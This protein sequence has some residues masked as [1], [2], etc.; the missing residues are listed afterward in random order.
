MW[1]RIKAALRR[2]GVIERGVSLVVR[3]ELI[4]LIEQQGNEMEKALRPFQKTP[5]A[6]EIQE[7]WVA[8]SEETVKA[9]E[10]LTQEMVDEVTRKLFE[11]NFEELMKLEVDIAVT[12]ASVAIIHPCGT[13]ERVPLNEL[14][15]E[16]LREYSKADA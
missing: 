1:N 8:R 9:G 4:E 12:G 6:S 15:E 2:Y 10:R 11:R 3:E 5:A 14:T 16:M 7:R 13:V